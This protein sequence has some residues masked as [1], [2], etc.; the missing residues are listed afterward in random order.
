MTKAMK[1]ALERI[2]SCV[3]FAS[4]ILAGAPNDDGSLNFKWSLGCIALAT[5]S[6]LILK[7][8]NKK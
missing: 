3:C 6:G 4:V 5:V 8:I 2:L 7:H 1:K